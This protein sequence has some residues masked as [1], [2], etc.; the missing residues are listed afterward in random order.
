MK[1]KFFL[2]A[3]KSTEDEE[4]Q[5][6]SIE[7]QLAELAEFA[8]RENIEIVLQNMIISKKF[9]SINDVVC[10]RAGGANT[11]PYILA[12]HFAK[13]NTKL[14]V[15]E[16]RGRAKILSPQPPSFL[17]ARAFGFCRAKR[18][19]QSEFRSKKVR[20]SFSNCDQSRHFKFSGERA[21]LLAPPS[22]GL[23]SHFS[24]YFRIKS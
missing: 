16:K 9:G 10:A 2:Y 17:P 3:R 7:A 19:N 24:A 18:G 12:A 8:K 22:A 20:A 14:G 1:T 4:R 15:G 5:V 13:R 21:C 6:M 23:R 11:T